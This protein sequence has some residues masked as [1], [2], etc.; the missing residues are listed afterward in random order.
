MIAGDKETIIRHAVQKP[1]T[2]LTAQFA[3]VVPYDLPLSLEG[4]MDVRHS[5]AGCKQLLLARA[6]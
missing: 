2:G 3:V 1:R 6:D 4:D 5:I